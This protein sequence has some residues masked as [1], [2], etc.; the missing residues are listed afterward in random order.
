MPMRFTIGHGYGYNVTNEG[1]LYIGPLKDDILK[2]EK[3]IE[4]IKKI[5]KE[6]EEMKKEENKNER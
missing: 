2:I 5:T 6:I 3:D 1:I 4:K